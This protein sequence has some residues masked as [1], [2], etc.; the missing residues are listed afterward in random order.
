MLAELRRWL[1]E[2]GPWSY[3]TLHWEA[4]LVGQVLYLEAEA[5]GVRGT[6]IG[7]FFDDSVHHSFGIRPGALHT[8]YHF[9]V[10]QPVDDPRL[11]TRP[12]YPEAVRARGALTPTV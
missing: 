1:D 7:C 9:T 2:D 8:L 11:A 3:R 12:R 6:G 4:G 5:H 10:G